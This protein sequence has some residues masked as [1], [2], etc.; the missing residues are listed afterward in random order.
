MAEESTTR[1]SIKKLQSRIPE[2]YGELFIGF[3]A[4]SSD[5]EGLHGTIRENHLEENR[6]PLRRSIWDD[7]KSV[8][9]RVLVDIVEC[10]SAE[11]AINSLAGR[12]EGSQAQ[13]VEGPDELGTISF[14]PPEKMAPAVFF[15]RGNLCVS[16]I[17]FASEAVE[18]VSFAQRINKR[19]SEQPATKQ[20]IIAL[21][22][23]KKSAGV[24]EKV[25]IDYE[26]PW[27]LAEDGYVKFIVQGGTIARRDKTVIITGTRAGELQLRLLVMEPGREVMG[28]QSTLVIE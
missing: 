27:S 23:Q 7:E 8:N 25:T 5:M 10:D 2:D 14:V 9:R 6:K 15:V 1:Y 13:L 11:D 17:S 24:G 4:K 16:I 20:N 28:G 18:V 12:L 19:M 22:P 3:C 26:L 21:S